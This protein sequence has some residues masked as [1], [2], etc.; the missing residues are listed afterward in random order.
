M[1]NQGRGQKPAKRQQRPQNFEYIRKL[2]GKIV[3]IFLRNGE[4][5]EGEIAGISTYEII[6]KVNNKNL[7]IY[8]HAIDYI[9]Y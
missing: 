8:K 9:E 7:L 6:V 4:K 2:N 3:K 5:I 1:R